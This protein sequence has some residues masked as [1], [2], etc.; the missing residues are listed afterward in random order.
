MAITGYF[1][2]GRSGG[3]AFSLEDPFMIDPT[4]TGGSPYAGGLK[5]DAAAAINSVTE[6]ATQAATQAAA[7]INPLYLIA[8]GMAL[9]LILRRR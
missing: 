7:N 3:G 9:I 5:R 1:S 8:A 2:G 4:D 6:A